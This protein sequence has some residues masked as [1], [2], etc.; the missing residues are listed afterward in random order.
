MAGLG[1]G[2]EAFG[3]KQ[4]KHNRFFDYDNDNDNDNDNDKKCIDG[5][6][7]TATARDERGNSLASGLS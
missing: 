3:L 6:R 7:V 1:R 5:Q 4:V 2:R